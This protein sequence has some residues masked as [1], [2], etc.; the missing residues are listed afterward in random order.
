MLIELIKKDI[1]FART[2]FLFALA[3]A[4]ILSAYCLFG[5]EIASDLSMN[6]TLSL[7]VIGVPMSRICYTEDSA[8][9]K[10]FLKS[11]PVEGYVV[12]LSRYVV[13]LGLS[14]VAIVCLLAAA[15]FTAAGFGVRQTLLTVAGVLCFTSYFSVYLS[16]FHWKG[17]YV[18]R[19]S[20]ALLL[21]I[22]FG[23]GKIDFVQQ[24]IVEGLGQASVMSIWILLLVLVVFI[25]LNILV[26]VA[27]FERRGS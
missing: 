27:L 10:T 22:F 12:V 18:T 23:V 13:L 11:L 6:M 26:S 19:Y 15:R 2:G 1:V 25:F 21:V 3:V 14:A 20:G 5:F 8:E 4:V 17:Y 24:F 9:T 7:G 16:L